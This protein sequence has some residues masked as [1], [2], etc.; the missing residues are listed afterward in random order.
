MKKTTRYEGDPAAEGALAARVENRQRAA[1][2]K[3]RTGKHT[4]HVYPTNEG[5]DMNYSLPLKK[6][7]LNEARVKA[8]LMAEAL[9]KALP[10]ANIGYRIE[11]DFGTEISQSS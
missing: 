5:Q 4:F 10:G 2:E 11:N 9:Q 6:A 1:L 7:T 8:I 3:A